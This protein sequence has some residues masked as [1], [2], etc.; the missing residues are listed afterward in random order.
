M[1]ILAVDTTHG[2]CSV[3]VLIDERITAQV[4]D[5]ENGKQAERLISIIEECLLE[6]QIAY[7]DLDAIAVNVGPGSF[8]GVRIGMAAVNGLNLVNKTPLIAVSSLEAVAYPIFKEQQARK[9]LVALD[10]KRGQL[11]CQLFDE[12]MNEL[13]QASLLTYEDAANSAPKSK[14]ILTGNGASLIEN[15]LKAYDSD[16]KTINPLAVSEPDSIAFI[17]A[18]KLKNGYR[19]NSISPLYIRKPDAKIAKKK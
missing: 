10:A 14:F 9:T 7:T 4:T 16:F 15:Q 11:Y 18:K 5:P 12:N 1:K 17:A 13:S 2:S 3:A 6:S 19:P 8:T